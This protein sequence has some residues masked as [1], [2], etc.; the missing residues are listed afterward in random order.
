LIK[1]LKY[2]TTFLFPLTP[3]LRSGQALPSPQR[4]EGQLV[5]VQHESV[6]LPSL[7]KGSSFI[8]EIITFVI[9]VLSS[10]FIIGC[11]GKP[12]ENDV[13]LI[14]E[15]LVKFE[16]GL[17]GKNVTVL[18]SVI[19]KKQKDLGSKLLTDFSAWGEIENV[20]IAN[21]RF[22][23]VKDSALV[24]LVLKMPAQKSGEELKEFEKP[25][26]LFLNKKRGKWSIKAYEIM[27]ND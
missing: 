6:L 21:K 15:L 23:I 7:H 10:L 18:D 17:K 11:V 5:S 12:P 24:E 14:K 16:R 22:T 26:N 27:K 19:N 3:S 8:S 9:I 2:H 25:V 13:A 1:G 4:G 20:Y